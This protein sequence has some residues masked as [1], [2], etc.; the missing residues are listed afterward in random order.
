MSL[1]GLGLLAG[2]FGSLVTF[3][4]L[5]RTR[6]N[7]THTAARIAARRDQ[8]S[9]AYVPTDGPLDGDQLWIDGRFIALV[10]AGWEGRR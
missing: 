2:G 5:G 4:L 7:D 1:L 8:L 6:D 9:R 10:L 3:G